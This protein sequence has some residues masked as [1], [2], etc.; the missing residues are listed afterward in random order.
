MEDVCVCKCLTGFLLCVH[1]AQQA[2]SH[3]SHLHRSTFT[4]PRSVLANRHG[5]IICNFIANGCN[6]QIFIANL[7]YSTDTFSA[8]IDQCTLLVCSIPFTLFYTFDPN[9][10][11]IIGV[12]FFAYIRTHT[13]THTT[14]V[15]FCVKILC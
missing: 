5:W 1:Y 12:C 9:A 3:T 6:F 7:F 15:R 2:H 13:H 8:V 11:A 4:L 14:Y 10:I